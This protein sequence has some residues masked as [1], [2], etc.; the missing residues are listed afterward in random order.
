[1]PN[2]VKGLLEVY[3]DMV[4]V[5]LVLEKFHREDSYV[6]VLRCGASTCSKTFLFFSNDLRLRLQ[7]V[8]QDRQL[9]FA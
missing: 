1:M 2:P 4:E 7:S 6:E 9:D 3:D 5:V 8:Q